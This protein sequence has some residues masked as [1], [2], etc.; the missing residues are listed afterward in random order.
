VFGEVLKFE[1]PI[2]LM[3]RESKRGIGKFSGGGKG[4]VSCLYYYVKIVQ[5][6]AGRS[7]ATGAGSPPGERKGASI[8]K[9]VENRPLF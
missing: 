9:V 2:F 5:N 8:S 6:R 3:G 1:N 4:G 7:F